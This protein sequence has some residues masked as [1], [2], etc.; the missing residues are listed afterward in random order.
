MHASRAPEIGRSGWI[1]L[2]LL[3]LFACF[4]L[5]EHASAADEAIEVARVAREAEPPHFET[6]LASG[7]KPA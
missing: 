3:A 6:L 5:D 4:G 2:A 7:R 1:A